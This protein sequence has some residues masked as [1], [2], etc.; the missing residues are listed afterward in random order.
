MT[1]DRSTECKQCLALEQQ[2]EELQRELGVYRSAESEGITDGDDTHPKADHAAAKCGWKRLLRFRTFSLRTLLLGVLAVALIIGPIHSWMAFKHRVEAQRHAIELLESHQ[3][4][5]VFA[6][7]IDAA[8][9]LVANPQLPDDRVSRWLVYLYG[10]DAVR[11]PVE[12]VSTGSGKPVSS[13]KFLPDLKKLSLK[14]KAEDLSHLRC[15]TNLEVLHLEDCQS[16]SF[17]FIGKLSNLR[18]LEIK[19]DNI[20]ND[21][22]GDL[23]FLNRLTKLEKLN[24]IHSEF[25]IIFAD[26]LY[27]PSV[28]KMRL[29]PIK[30]AMS[31]RLFPNVEILDL[32]FANIN[33]DHEF[34]D[35]AGIEVLKKLR[36]LDVH[37]SY[38][39]HDISPLRTLTNLEEIDLT[40]TSI[41]DLS[42]LSG[43]TKLQELS[44]GSCR[45]E[46]LD[47]SPLISLPSLKKLAIREQSLTNPLQVGELQQLEML[48]IG[49]SLSNI[50]PKHLLP[51][52][53]LK[54]LCYDFSYSANEPDFQSL[55]QLTEL[56]ELYVINGGTGITDYDA[57]PLRSLKNLR[58]PKDHRL[59]FHSTTFRENFS[60]VQWA[61]ED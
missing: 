48:T 58:L 18:E 29:W 51:L 11:R 61:P 10:E 21:P 20:V 15:L 4:E 45:S 25:Y 50:R 49:E 41:H 16:T 47:L 19:M 39:L 38:E 56:E 28:K 53:H 2:V 37:K 13:L 34:H 3:C 54:V 42:P 26:D 43:M 1:I 35:L 7:E 32:S 12:A 44:I 17:D 23:T 22:F 24:L 57:S 6:H 5:I 31:L 52:K 9:N 30:D 40:D 14:L 8:G 59:E 46:P 33:Y 36:I 60:P 55:A 27:L